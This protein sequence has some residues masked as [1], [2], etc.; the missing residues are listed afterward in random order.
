MSETSFFAPLLK[1]SKQFDRKTR[2]V[3]KEETLMANTI[4]DR[5]ALLLGSQRLCPLCPNVPV[6]NFIV[7]GGC[8]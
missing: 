3:C 5:V 4:T 6:G 8:L 1:L 7:L 2:V